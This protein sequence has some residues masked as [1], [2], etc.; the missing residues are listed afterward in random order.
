MDLLTSRL[1]AFKTS[2]VVFFFPKTFPMVLKGDALC[3]CLRSWLQVKLRKL[4]G[5]KNKVQNVLL[6]ARIVEE[7][8]KI[9]GPFF[10]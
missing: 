2:A 6:Y 8:Q 10:E 9:P 7:S 4:R 3:V 5:C 1:A